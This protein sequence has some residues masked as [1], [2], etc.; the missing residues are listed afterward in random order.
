MERR[1]WPL[2]AFLMPFADTRMR[3]GP[4]APEHAHNQRVSEE[5]AH[6][7]AE[8]SAAAEAAQI[9]LNNSRKR[10]AAMLKSQP[11]GSKGRKNAR[12]TNESQGGRGAAQ[13]KGLRHFAMQVCNKIEAKGRTTYNEVAD[14]LVI[15]LKDQPDG[16]DDK[17]IRRRVYDAFN[18]LLA[19][20]IIGREGKKEIVWK[21]FPGNNSIG[22]DQAHAERA[23]RAAAVEKKQKELQVRDAMRLHL[24]TRTAAIAILAT[25]AHI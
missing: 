6:A 16:G 1:G 4:A 11:D 15:E 23:R 7:V 25:T 17:N 3:A 10:L 5:A 13:N 22:L 24:C 8:A 2:H 14:E 21:G 18:V 9:V 20:G 19:V 12:T